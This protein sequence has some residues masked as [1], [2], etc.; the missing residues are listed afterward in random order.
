MFTGRAKPIRTIGDP[1]YQ[2]PD[3][4]SSAVVS[5]SS[6]YSALI[7]FLHLF[8]VHTMYVLQLTS[9]I[10][11]LLFQFHFSHQ[12]SVVRTAKMLHNSHSSLLNS[13]YHKRRV[14]QLSAPCW[15]SPLPRPGS[16]HSPIYKKL[17]QLA[18]ISRTA[19]LPFFNKHL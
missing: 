17:E 15:S 14:T 16:K 3:S 19:H 7:L 2:R 8:L 10:P 12:Y 1:D 5:F 13:A 9:T 11:S 6:V 18:S 4:W